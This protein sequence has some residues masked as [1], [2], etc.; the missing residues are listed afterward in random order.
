M[1]C[2]R[3]REAAVRIRHRGW[4]RG[5]AGSAWGGCR[6]GM[7]K[8]QSVSIN[9]TT[10]VQRIQLMTKRVGVG[11]L[12][13]RPTR[14]GWPARVAAGSAYQGG[15]QGRRGKITGLAWGRGGSCREG[16]A[17]QSV[18]MSFT[19]VVHTNDTRSR[20]GGLRGWHREAAGKAW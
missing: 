6:D 11:G 1:S 3:E 4:S 8:W 14:G 17:K 7:E 5:A 10:V 16:N 19:T 12:R 20:N 13:G 9:L 2:A 15:L 18:Y